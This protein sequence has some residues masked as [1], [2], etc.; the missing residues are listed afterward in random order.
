MQAE[1]ADIRKK[2]NG[3]HLKNI[4]LIDIL[5]HVH[6]LGTYVH[7]CKRWSFYGQIY[8][9]E[10]CPQTAMK[11]TTMTNN[12]WLSRLFGIYAKWVNKQHKYN[13]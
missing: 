11:A 6:E 3:C 10:A 1:E 7:V 9:Q 2:K 13:G 12:S 5:L 8:D 4:D